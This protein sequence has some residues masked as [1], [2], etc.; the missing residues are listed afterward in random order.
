MNTGPHR[1]MKADSVTLDRNSGIFAESGRRSVLTSK[2]TINCSTLT[3]ANAQKMI[4]SAT[5]VFTEN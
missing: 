4:G 1:S 2:I 5:T 3:L